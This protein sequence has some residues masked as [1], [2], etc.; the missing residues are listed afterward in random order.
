MN[1][2]ISAVGGQG[3]LLTSR[4]LGKLAQ[5]LNL[6]VKVSEVHGMSQRGGS[7][8]TYVKFGEKI[9]SPI[10]EKGTADVVLAFELLEGARYASYLREKGTLIVSSQRIDPMPVISGIMEYPDKLGEELRELPISLYEVNA[11]ELAQRAGSIRTTNVVL[12]GVLAKTTKIEKHQWIKAL[13]EIVPKGL[14][15]INL[16]AFDLGYTLDASIE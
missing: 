11:M 9:Y 15:E 6:D 2:L 4:I 10:V 7:V 5:N 8:V 12:L 14:L 1:I 3:A 16:K 13:E